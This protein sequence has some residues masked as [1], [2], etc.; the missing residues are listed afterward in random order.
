MNDS[1]ASASHCAQPPAVVRDG[2]VV[3]RRGTVQT[4][5]L[6]TPSPEGSPS[7]GGAIRSII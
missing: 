5:C 7:Y 6:S 4:A 1:T 2:F 3:R